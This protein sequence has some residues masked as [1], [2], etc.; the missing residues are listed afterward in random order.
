M[1]L[2]RLCE[3]E[4]DLS[5]LSYREKGQFFTPTETAKRC[6]EV[7]KQV[8]EQNGFSFEEYTCLEPSA[9]NGSFSNLLPNSLAMDIEPQT[10]GIRKEDFLAWEPVKVETIF[11][12]WT[13]LPELGENQQEQV[14]PQG[15]QIF[16]YLMEEHLLLLVIKIR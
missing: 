4:V 5:K 13:S 12:I 7:T 6:I 3:E 9:G 16:F 1:D 14:K 2:K 10:Q 8:L 11:Q 15:F